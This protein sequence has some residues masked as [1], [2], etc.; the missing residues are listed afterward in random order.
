MT[1]P[2]PIKR[3]RVRKGLDIQI[4]GAPEPGI[5]ELRDTPT[6]GLF[7]QDYRGIVPRLL[8]D[9]GDRVRL[10]QALFE[11]RKR[12][13]IKVT[14]PASGFVT[15]ITHGDRR[16]L[17]S[18][19]IE[20]TGEDEQLFPAYEARQIVALARDTVVDSLLASGLWT[21]LRT[22]PFG[23]VPDP[24]TSPRSIFV[25]AI[26]TNPLA[27]DP[28]MVIAE[29]T[30]DFQTGLTVI[31]RLTDEP[32]FLCRK[33][34]AAIPSGDPER[35]TVAEFEGP[36]P[37]GLPGTHIHLLDPAGSGRTAWHLGY[38]D[39]I[40][41]GKLFTTGRLW[42]ERVVSIAGPG[43]VR[44]RL[45]R[46]RLGASVEALA[47]GELDDVERR[48]VSGPVLSGYRAFG[49]SA[50]LGRYHTQVSVL[51]ESAAPAAGGLLNRVRAWI[52]SGSLFGARIIGDSPREFTTALNGQLT[53]LVPIDGFERVMPLDILPVPLFRA[54]LVGDADM[55]SALGCLELDEE[56]LAL[57]TFL[58]PGKQD[59][60]ARLR[61]TLDLIE[62]EGL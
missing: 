60:G 61:S 21:A 47:A 45:I 26:D 44:P 23:N 32:V 31:S 11:D 43:V 10:G 55:A 16:A 42:V 2:I 14:S 6:V 7:G 49:A 8:V 25:T 17:K 38:Q 3:F 39:V 52:S 27:A 34:G 20:R 54:L 59:Y 29:H 9:E 50:F 35:I 58:C 5:A 46:T 33:E 12:P 40:A 57:A 48:V 19:V 1:Q 22:R 53:A 41:I 24:E 18:I 28:V 13:V 56:D 51:G 37:A 4:S 15:A 30:E 62:R 36:H